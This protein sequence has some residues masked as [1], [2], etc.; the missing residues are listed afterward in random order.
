MPNTKEIT[1]GNIEN[2]LSITLTLISRLNGNRT[3]SDTITSRTK[4]I[5]KGGNGTLSSEPSRF[6]ENS[7]VDLFPKCP[8]GQLPKHLTD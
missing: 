6:I 1:Q 8:F 5:I 2:A 3:Q 7:F 4:G